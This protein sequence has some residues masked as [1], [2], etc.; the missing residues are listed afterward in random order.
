MVSSRVVVS[1]SPPV[2]ALLVW[3]YLLVLLTALGMQWLYSPRLYLLWQ[4][5]AARLVLTEH[6]KVQ[7]AAAQVCRG[8]GSRVRV[9]VHPNPHPNPHPHPR[10]NQVPRLREQG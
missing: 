8:Y 9:R 7:E 1:S 3:L 6:A 5:H 2:A 10:P 4:V